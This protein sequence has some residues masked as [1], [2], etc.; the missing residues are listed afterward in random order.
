MNDKRV[1]KPSVRNKNGHWFS[2]A[3]GKG[4][5]FGK[6]TEVTKAKATSLLWAALAGG[7][8]G[9]DL[10]EKKGEADRLHQALLAASP[11]VTPALTLRGLIDL[12]LGWL[13]KH[14]SNAL[15]RE[16]KRHLD[17]FATL[18]GGRPATSIT[19]G[20]LEAFQE[21]LAGDGKMALMYIKKHTTSI[22]ACFNK[23]VKMGWLPPAFK[24]FVHVESIRLDPRPLLEGDL[25]TRGEVR[26]LLDA[27]SARPKLRAMLTIYH[28]TGCRT[29]EP[30]EARVGDFQLGSRTLVLGKHKRSKTLRDPIP[31]TI[32]LNA[33][34]YQAIKRQC[35]G[36]AGDEFIFPNRAGKMFT[37]VL[38]D[39][40]FARC[41]KRA[42]VREG[43][44]PYSFRHLYISEMLMA[45]IDALLV[46]RMAGTSV[47]MIETTYGHF[48]TSSYQ[49][50]Q[51]KLDAVRA[52]A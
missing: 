10:V 14:R 43:I 1:R 52:E 44:T 29:H 23:G 15:W 51:A 34:A 7:D 3:G 35:E 8:R 4:R 33:A 22:R 6:I 20:D 28:A 9:P 48:K 42:G 37:S 26:A 5:Y 21:A 45:G 27:T 16:A 49:D 30:L 24:P 32:I 41:R 19:G 38:F 11:P 31:R 47:K 39:D 17:R 25:P 2:D 36:R 46:A 13:L 40:M 50:A 18:H 12:Y